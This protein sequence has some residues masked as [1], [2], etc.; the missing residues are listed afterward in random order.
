MKIINVS[1]IIILNTIFAHNLYAAQTVYIP[2]GSGNQVIAVDA[3]TDKITN[4]YPGVEN[5]HGLGA[6][7]D[8][9]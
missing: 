3:D 1:I 4:A 2:L 7:P 8:G 6:T 5:P 9:E